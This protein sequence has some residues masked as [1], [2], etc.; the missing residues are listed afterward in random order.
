M[1]KRILIHYPIFNIGGAERSTLKLVN[2]FLEADWH[3][4]VVMTTGGGELE[5]E[6]DNR[7]NIKYLRNRSAGNRFL[8]NE[9]LFQKVLAL[10][11]LVKYLIY[12]IQELYR[13]KNYKN[14]KYDLAMISLHGLSPDFCL[15]YVQANT[16]VQWIRS[17]LKLCD[18]EKKA[19]NHILKYGNRVDHYLCVS[20]TVHHSFCQLYPDLSSKAFRIYNMLEPEKI[21][22]KAEQSE[23][24]YGDYGSNV[25][26]IVTVCRIS[27]KSK[28]L[29]RM[30][31][32]L[33]RL[34]DEHHNVVWFIVGD[35]PDRE[36]VQE[37]IVKFDLQGKMILLGMK[38]NPYPYYK[39]ADI[40]A[41]LSYFEGL[42]GAVNEAK[43]LGKPVIATKFSG[44][45]EQIINGVNGLIVNNEM[46]AIYEG[47]KEL[48]TNESLR[49]RLT[50][51]YLPPSIA[52]DALKMRL[53]EELSS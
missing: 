12:R 33:K 46:E 11:D 38:P 20:N 51:N 3:V 14:I 29:L 34:A 43:V 17:D 37:E 23:N 52:N 13:K 44:V 26:K 10:D 2:K 41:T 35:G 48:I 53:L 1:N 36:K 30:V 8:K 25:L 45:E 28:G 47:L 50:N 40:S 42:C 21:L 49:L 18:I 22:E 6:I 16:T 24:P 4:D 31:H 15:N 5:N 39:H 7:A 27:D 9:S 19:H 32:L